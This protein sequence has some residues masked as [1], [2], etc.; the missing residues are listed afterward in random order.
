MNFK[1]IITIFLLGTIAFL[2]IRSVKASPTATEAGKAVATTVTKVQEEITKNPGIFAALASTLGGY[3]T[4]AV[5]YA[6]KKS[7]FT[8]NPVT[9]AKNT[10]SCIKNHPEATGTAAA[11]LAS[12]F[13]Y[14]RYSTWYNKHATALTELGR[15]IHQDY[16]NSPNNSA[17]A[18]AYAKNYRTWYG[19]KN[20][21]LINAV[22]D[23][24]NTQPTRSKENYDIIIGICGN[25][26]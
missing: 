6:E 12:L 3:A 15:L 18:I 9:A 4:S 25:N 1:R 7:N 14:N 24:Y 13:I 2:T 20:Q 17:R 21:T 11:I 19:F 5:D 8:F 10:Y 23:F 16:N 26:L 22:N